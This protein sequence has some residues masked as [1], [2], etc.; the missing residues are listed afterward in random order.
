MIIRPDNN[1]TLF[2]ARPPVITKRCDATRK[3]KKMLII[4]S[5]KRSNTHFCC[6]TARRRASKYQ[7]TRY[8][9]SITCCY[10]PDP[11]R[12]GAVYITAAVGYRGTP[13]Q[14]IP[15]GIAA[16]PMMC[17]SR[18]TTSI[19]ASVTAASRRSTHSCHSSISARSR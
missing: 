19:D 8:S 6:C 17:S 9:I 14:P 5:T 10:I 13:G 15:R 4:I 1:R 3:K 12:E 7:M 18:A 2:V 16:P 11:R